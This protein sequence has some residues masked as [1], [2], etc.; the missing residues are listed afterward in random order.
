MQ[1]T[2]PNYAGMS[3]T[4]IG[5]GIEGL[6]LVRFFSDRGAKVTVSDA[7]PAERL[8][9][10]L[11]ALA[12]RELSL[13]FGGNRAE[14]TERADLVAVSQ[15]APLDLPSILRARERGIPVTSLTQLFLRHCPGIV[16]G[17]SGSSGKTTTT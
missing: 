10:A 17:I 15:G 6:D 11:A 5:L 7:R 1:T 3:V 2:A 4:V 8:G 12:G 13:S 16:V 9:P 14:A